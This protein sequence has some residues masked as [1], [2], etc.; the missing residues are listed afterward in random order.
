MSDEKKEI[1]LKFPVRRAAGL[2]VTLGTQSLL[3]GFMLAAT[4]FVPTPMLY[5]G[6]GFAL[7]VSLLFLLCLYI[8]YCVWR[9]GGM[10]LTVD[11]GK[12]S[13][14]FEHLLVMSKK[15]FLP[16]RPERYECGLQEILKV[17]VREAEMLRFVFVTEM[18]DILVTNRADNFAGLRDWVRENLADKIEYKMFEWL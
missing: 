6:I 11:V 9:S 18:G 13:I 15:R 12:N 4:L 10:R 3:A 8:Y 7:L 5:V 17:R 1:V 16:L 2:I 14:C